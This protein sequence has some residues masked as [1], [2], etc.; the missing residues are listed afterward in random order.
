MRKCSL[1]E[2]RYKMFTPHNLQFCNVKLQCTCRCMFTTQSKTTCIICHRQCECYMCINQTF[3]PQIMGI[4]WLTPFLMI[5]LIFWFSWW[6]DDG[7][8]ELT[9]DWWSGSE[10]SYFDDSL[11][12]L[13][14]FWWWN[15]YPHFL[16]SGNHCKFLMIEDGWN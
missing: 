11:T 6:F 14:Y 9:D 4:G 15:D 3:C 10:S 5:Y 7:K 8:S 1:F 16:W 2:A 13:Y 12:N